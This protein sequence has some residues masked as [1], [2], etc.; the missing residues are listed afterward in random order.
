MTSD[1][2]DEERIAE[3]AVAAT[4]AAAAGHPIDG[5]AEDDETAR[6]VATVIQAISAARPAP[7]PR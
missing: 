2:R 5:G 3:L 4:V 6:R 7:D 1:D